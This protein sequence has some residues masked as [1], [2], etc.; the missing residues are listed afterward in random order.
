MQDIKVPE[1]ASG[2]AYKDNY[3][4][5][6]RNRFIYWRISHDVLELVEH[7]LDVNLV[8]C[9]VRYKF[10]D[11]PILDGISIHET[12]NSV[13]ILVATVSS[14]H[15]LTFPHPDKIHKQVNNNTKKKPINKLIDYN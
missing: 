8:N 2:Y 1:R 6:T 4:Y 12:V 10:T 14:I 3:K 7:S 13:I 15:K 11:T 9:K 5:Y